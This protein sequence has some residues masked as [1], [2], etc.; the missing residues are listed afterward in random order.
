MDFIAFVEPLMSFVDF[1]GAQKTSTSSFII[2]RL[3]TAKVEMERKAN[4]LAAVPG[5]EYVAGWYNAFYGDVW[6]TY[7]DCF[8]HDKFL[9]ASTLLDIRI[10]YKVLTNEVLVE[11][12]DALR[13]LA[14]KNA[15]V[16]A[17]PPPEPAREHAS[18]ILASFAT[19]STSLPAALSSYAASPV[20]ALHSPSQEVELWLNLYATMSGGEAPPQCFEDPSLMFS[21]AC[22]GF[23]DFPTLLSL[24]KDLSLILPSEAAAERVSKNAK[25]TDAPQR[26]HTP[27]NLVTRTFF[28]ANKELL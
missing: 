2:P 8:L 18:S 11:A 23:Q 13:E 14:A 10:G 15:L 24:H 17:A 4:E 25:F 1:T 5:R 27:E 21:A 20:S 9:L 28:V 19:V 16:V 6:E 7:L 12:I 22:N 3:I 26:T